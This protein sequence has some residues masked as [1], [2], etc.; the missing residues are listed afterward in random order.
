MPVTVV[1]DGSIGFNDVD[2][3]YPEV[4]PSKNDPTAR[5]R[6]AEPGPAPAARHRTGGTTCCI[7]G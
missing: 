5:K 4:K 2:F 1:K 7:P 3:S 6:G